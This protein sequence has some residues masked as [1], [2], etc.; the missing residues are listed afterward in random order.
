M[1]KQQQPQRNCAKLRDFG[2]G[3]VTS[4]VS[5]RAGLLTSS[6]SLLLSQLQQSA[7]GAEAVDAKQGV[8]LLSLAWPPLA[9]Q[10][11]P[12]IEGKIAVSWS[13]ETTS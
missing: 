1:Y 7:A 13:L 3:N 5:A 8:S 10:S 11:M 12:G 4:T 2:C 6:E 9:G